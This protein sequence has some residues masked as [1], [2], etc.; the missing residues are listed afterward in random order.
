MV[1]KFLVWAV[2][3]NNPN[4]IKGFVDSF[5]TLEDAQHF[6]E[7]RNYKINY[8]HIKNLDLVIEG[9]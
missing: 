7:L 2:N 4:S 5:K 6:C 1:G 3:K 9:V 8:Y